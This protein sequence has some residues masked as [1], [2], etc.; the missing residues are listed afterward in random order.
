MRKH[1]PQV[2]LRGRYCLMPEPV[3]VPVM[4]AAFTIAAPSF[5][6]FHSASS[7]LL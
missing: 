7:G 4:L 3:G 1:V 2:D 5:V 6:V